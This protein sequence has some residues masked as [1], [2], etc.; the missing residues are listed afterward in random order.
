MHEQVSTGAGAS[1]EFYL[2]CSDLVTNL[3]GRVGESRLELR[4]HSVFW[5]GCEI[6]ICPGADGPAGLRIEEEL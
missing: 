3:T 4:K 5:R 6:G 1:M 2:V